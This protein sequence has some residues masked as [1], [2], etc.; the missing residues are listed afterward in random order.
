MKPPGRYGR[1]VRVATGRQTWLSAAQEVRH[2]PVAQ[3]PTGAT[4]LPSQQFSLKVSKSGPWSIQR[5]PK[6]PNGSGR[7]S[8]HRLLVVWNDCGST[9]IAQP[10]C[11]VASE[12][13]W[14]NVT[15]RSA[16]CAMY[17]SS[18]Y[19]T[20]SN[21][22]MP[23]VKG[24]GKAAVWVS[25]TTCHW[26]SWLR[27]R[28]IRERSASDGPSG[29]TSTLQSQKPTPS[30]PNPPPWKMKW[31]KPCFDLTKDHLQF[32]SRP[33]S[34]S[35]SLA[36]VRIALVEDLRQRDAARA[37]GASKPNQCTT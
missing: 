30:P 15:H 33:P 23:W 17:T 24:Q 32:A 11:A 13:R 20:A 9:N 21:W 25:E 35:R 31:N 36:D 22:Q 26:R 6:S 29:P 3:V 14:R 37:G 10:P 1:A 18:F 8:F 5:T 27:F 16:V 2:S 19:P 34:S 4:D 12:K 7:S 28:S